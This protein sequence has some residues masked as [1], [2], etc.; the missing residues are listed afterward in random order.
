MMWFWLLLLIGLHAMLLCLRFAYIVSRPRPW[1]SH[2]PVKTMVVLG[3][4]AT[5][6]QLEIDV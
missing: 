1:K 3:S 5:P 4:G 6:Y 2:L